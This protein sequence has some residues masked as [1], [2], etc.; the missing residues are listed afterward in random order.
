[1]VINVSAPRRLPRIHGS[2]TG[3]AA[4]RLASTKVELTGP[5]VGSLQAPVQSDGS[6]DFATVIPGLY[7]LRLLQVPG[8]TPM[9]VTV[10][11]WDTTQVQVAMP[12]R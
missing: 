5:I 3:L 9:N 12:A 2:V 6:F 11:G 7:R 1:V 10:A 8:F 4:D